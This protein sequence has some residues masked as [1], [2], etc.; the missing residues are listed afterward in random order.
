MRS[1]SI[2]LC[3]GLAWSA[4]TVFGAGE[5]HAYRRSKTC[6]PEEE[7][8]EVPT[9]IPRCADGETPFPFFWP[10]R[11]V[12]F[13]IARQGCGEYRDA[14]GNITPD[15]E[16]AIVEAFLVWNEP[17]CS[18]LEFVY[19]GQTETSVLNP[20][21]HANVVAW[22]DPWPYG[23]AAFALTSV[24]T[25]LD[26]EIIDADMELNSDRYAFSVTEDPEE[27]LVD[28]RNTVTHEAGHVL[29]LAHSIEAE[30]TMDADADLAE[31][32]KRTLHPDDIEGL[33]AAYPPGVYAQGMS[34]EEVND[35]TCAQ[36][37]A[38]APAPPL[39][40]VLGGLLLAARVRRR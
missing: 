6:L 5:A 32:L 35:T 40:L 18:D 31:T 2:L 16:H 8:G 36:S 22:R 21:D 7:V 34:A 20:E 12:P 33:C 27:G 17:A 19:A 28:V 3:A 26:G 29:G 37:G 14:D 1:L 25:T 4:L 10:E 9:T 13:Y 24:T 23:G 11:T 39:W 38:D 30:S 15:L